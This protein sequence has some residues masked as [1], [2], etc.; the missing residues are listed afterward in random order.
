MPYQRTPRQFLR[1]ILI[2]VV[3]LSFSVMFM[4]QTAQA[5][6]GGQTYTVQSGD[7]LYRISLR[8]GVS[9][10][11]IMTVNPQITNPNLIYVGQVINIPDGA[12]DSGGGT[13]T[14]GGTDSSGTDTG[15][16]S[17]GGDTGGGDTG[18]TTSYTVQAGDTLYRIA[19]RFNMTLSAIV[20]L[21]P[22]ITNP[23]LIYVG[24]IVTISGTGGTTSGG[25]TTGG[26][27]TGGGTT[28]GGTTG[29][30]NA[31]SGFEIGGHV[32]GYGRVGEMN[33]ARMT[34]VKKQVKWSRGEDTGAAAAA[35]N[36][37][38]NNGFK[39]LISI[40]GYKDQMG[41]FNN[42]VNE[43]AA[44]VGQVAQLGPEAI[45]IWNEP[46]IDREWPA[47]QISG[48]NY[49]QLLA[50]SYTAIKNSNG[51]VM[52]ISG[53]PAPTG[54]FG[55]AG[56]GSGGCNDDVFLAQMRNAGAANYLDCV[57]AHYNEGIISPDFRSGDPRGNHYTRYF[58]GMLDLY[59]NTFG[60]AR[61]VCWTELGYLSPEGY[62][63]LPSNFAWAG[64]TSI[65]EHAEWLGRAAYLSRTSG[66]VRLMIVWN[67]DFTQYGDDPMAGYAIVRQDGSCPACG[68]LAAALQ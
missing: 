25:G 68:Q 49:T 48:A 33:S 64:D 13:D 43:Y 53:A 67:V 19:T 7:N 56:C 63:P 23:N 17:G 6:D 12:T 14:G 59:Y 2:L 42:Y 20:A 52:V 39:I 5:Q 46:N 27:T 30:G 15:G 9:I 22:Q 10:S 1:N 57:G 62:G 38:H 36:E 34:W 50:A 18:S 47:G 58:Y 61:K 24:Q 26:G 44:F 16:S 41:D 55:S 21:N 4:P 51:N 32:A 60:G 40:V 29:G 37:A 35:I 11:A 3:I 65:A 54:Y 28:G 45:E 31:G 66:R 8:F